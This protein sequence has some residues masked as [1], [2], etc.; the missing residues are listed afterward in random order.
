MSRVEHQYRRLRLWCA[1]RQRRQQH[2]ADQ[3]DVSYSL[4]GIEKSTDADI[5]GLTVTGGSFTDG[6]IGIDFAKDTA[7]GQAGNGLATNVTISG[8]HFEDMTAKGIYVEA[9]SNALITDVRM[10]HVGFYGAGAA[11]VVRRLLS[12][13]HRS[14]PEERRQSQRP[15]PDRLR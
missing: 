10:D 1:L 14:Q 6:Y 3:F 13:R 8:T 9:L 5:N 4:I 7:V 15:D 2:H 11:S 12:A